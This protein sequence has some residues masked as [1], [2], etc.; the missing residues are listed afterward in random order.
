MT[1]KTLQVV[2]VGRDAG[3]KRVLK[4]TERA[5][6]TLSARMAKLGTKMASVGRKLTIGLT[7][8]ILAV[9]VASFKLG[10]DLNESLSKTGVIFKKSSKEV[11]RWSKT[12][13]EAMGLSRA[14]A[15]EGAADFG[16]MFNTIGLGTK[17]AAKMST[18]MTQL[19]A[20]MGSLNN[21]DPSEM[22]DR[23]RSGL[24]GE[25]EPLRR[26]GVLL[27]AA[28]VKSFAYKNGIAEV[29]NELTEAEKVQ[30]RYGLILEQTKTAQGDFA[31]TSGEAANQTRIFQAK[32]KDAGAALGQILL[33]AGTAMIGVVAGLAE[34]FANLPPETQKTVV[35]LGAVAAAV[36]PL[37]FVTGKLMVAFGEG[38]SLAKGIKGIGTA[39]RGI[40][41]GVGRA[42]VALRAFSV[43]QRLLVAGGVGLAIA[44]LGALWLKFRDDGGAV[45]DAQARI[46]KWG[47]ELTRQ[48]KRSG[49]ELR[50]LVQ[51]QDILKA[52]VKELREESEKTFGAD[53]D[54]F[55]LLPGAAES[56]ADLQ[57]QIAEL[58]AKIG[59]TAPKIKEL[60][61]AQ[62]DAAGAARRQREG[63]ASLADGTKDFAT[64]T[65]EGVKALQEFHSAMLS[66]AGGELG[67]RQAVISSE[68]AQQD[69]NT[70]IAEYGPGSAE[71]R[72]ATLKLE[73]AQLTLAGASIDLT[74]TQAGLAKKFQDNPA[75]ID[76][77][78]RKLQE[79]AAQYPNSAGAIQPLID[80][81]TFYKLSIDAIPPTKHT[82]INVDSD[83]AKRRIDA[84][85]DKLI[86]L[87]GAVV[88]IRVGGGAT[89]RAHGG[90]VAAG[91]PY[92]VG[93]K[94][95]ELFV[96]SGDGTI[97]PN[98]QL[99]GAAPRGG[100]AMTVNMT[101]VSN[102]GRAVVEAIKRYER[103][104]TSTWRAA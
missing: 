28:E 64:A 72:D 99:G 22:L 12:S 50:S 104:N 29:G 83:D 66:A 93:E 78:I 70:S 76:A 88:G 85:Q 63:I 55:T 39:A 59:D 13:A 23:L 45:E 91:S 58:E 17:Q 33:P 21:E 4:E 69:L 73:Q 42:V 27:S 32:A 89:L 15:L 61:S 11:K 90:P 92:V 103:R 74:D 53:A 96:P 26:F 7:L 5:A 1:T 101:V 94:G 47:E 46:K 2:V 34:G 67:L 6:G 40:A 65:E 24:A 10:S 3:G 52:K 77:E 41:S 97:I 80:R 95:P 71:A 60:R 8:P 62:D 37:L 54:V 86:R 49:D 35:A 9:G 100:N 56:Y 30:A 44:A 82:K 79:A 20:D 18:S 31:R 25:A 19:A 81:L 98:G 102:D 68:K 38:G 48:A 16:N 14:E 75:L 87:N 57:S 36:G 43:A 51:S 84:V